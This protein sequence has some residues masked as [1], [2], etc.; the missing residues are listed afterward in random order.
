MPFNYLF[1][2]LILFI[3]LFISVKKNRL[4]FTAAITAAVVGLLIFMGTGFTGIAMIGLFFLLGTLATSFKINVKEKLGAAEINKGGRT[5]GQVIANGGVAAIMGLLAWLYPI[6]L[7]VFKMMMAG[8]L[9]SATADTLS[10]ELGTVYGKK[11]YNILSFKIDRRGENGVISLEG[12]FIGIIGSVLVA[13]IHAFASG[14]NDQFWGIVIAGT[15]GNLTDSILGATLERK[16]LIGND[17]VNFINTL[18]GAFTVYL[19]M[20]LL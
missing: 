3:V 10:S 11:F 12:T 8:A 6:Q 19:L 1:F 4:T 18:V 2:V 9:A 15:I 5:A 17:T 7:L 16:R 20:K 14:W 13:M